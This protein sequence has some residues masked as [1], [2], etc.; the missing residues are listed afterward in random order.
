MVMLMDGSNPVE[1]DPTLASAWQRTLAHA[2]IIL[3]LGPLI[4]PGN[5]MAATVMPVSP[6]TTTS[7]ASNGTPLVNIAAP[8]ASGL[9]Q[10]QYS[11]FDVDPR[12]LIL[13]NSAQPVNT[14]LG[15]YVPGNANVSDGSAR[16]I[17][18]EVTTANPSRLQGYIEVAGSPADVIVANPWGIS[19]E[20]CG[21]LNTARAVLSTGRPQ[22][23]A[24]ERFAGFLVE[25]GTVR[26]E[27]GGLNAS[28]TQ[29]L[30][31]YAR[32]LEVNDALHAQ[33][34]RVVLGTNRID[35]AGN[36]TLLPHDA[37]SAPAYALDSSGLGG[38]YANSIR[39]IGTEAG[40]GMRLAAPVAALTG[41]LEITAS[42][43]VR[44]A[45]SSAATDMRIST[46]HDLVLNENSSAGG[47]AQLTAGGSI[48]VDEDVRLSAADTAL[49]AAS[50]QTRQGSEIAARGS[51]VIAA[52]SQ[53][54]RGQVGSIGHMTLTGDTV[55]SHEQLVASAGL[56]VDALQLVNRGRVDVQEGNLVIRVGQLDNTG[57][58]LRAAGDLNLEMP[59]FSRSL[60]GGDMMAGGWLTVATQG[61]ITIDGEALHTA[62]GVGLQS[63]IGDIR[64]STELTANGDMQLAGQHIRLD[65]PARLLAQGLLQT[66]S[67]DLYN[68]GLM[69]G[70]QGLQ[71]DLTGTLQNGDP[72]LFNGAA[73]LS[74]GNIVIGASNGGSANVVR[75]NGGHIESLAGSIDIR[76]GLLHNLN[77]GWATSPAY[78]L[79]AFEYSISQESFDTFHYCCNRAGEDV[80]SLRTETLTTF[81]DF[82]SLGH[83]G[84]I[85]AS[86][87]IRI[88]A[89]HVIND[90]SVI[91][92]GGVLDIAA[93]QIDNTGTRLTDR[94]TRT[95][96]DHWHTCWYNDVGRL[97]CGARSS[98]PFISHFEGATEVLPAILEGGSAVLLHGTVVNGEAVRVGNSV[99][100]DTGL[101][102]SLATDVP[103][104][105]G[106]VDPTS[107]P[108]FNLPANGIFQRTT[109]PGHRYLI[110]TNPALN[111]Y[112]GFLG[113]AYLLEHLVWAPEITQ[114]RLGD[115]Y[116]EI[117]LIRQALMAALGTRFIDPRVTDER[118]QYEHLMQS[119]V[120]AS[121]TLQISPG[122][123]L[124]REQI[125]AL[126]QDIVWLEERLIQGERVLV[127]VVYLAQGSTRLLQDGAVIGGGALA[128]SG[129]DFH[130]A[131]LVRSSGNISI[132]SAEQLQNVQGS[133]VADGIVQLR[134]GGD[135]LNES[136]VISGHDVLIA[137][138]GNITHRTWS[139]QDEVESRS[140]SSWNTRAGDIATVSA[141]GAV[142]QVA[143][144]DIRLQGAAIA[145]ENVSLV[146]GNSIYLEAISVEEG[147]RYRDSEWQK[148]EENVRHLQ[149][150]IEAA[151]SLSLSA[152]GDI[153]AIA[154]RLAAGGNIELE[155]GRD[156][157][158]L[159]AEDRDYQEAHF[160][161]EGTVGDK[162][163]DMTHDARRLQ[164]SA[165]A[166]GGDVQINAGGN[167]TLYASTVEAAGSGTLAAG[168]NIH[169]VSGVDTVHHSEQSSK[170]KVAT[171][172]THQEGYVQERL[173]T[174][175]IVTG[176]DLALH[177]GNTVQLTGAVLHT[178]KTLTIGHQALD[179]VDPA[180]IPAN[181]IVDTVTLSNQSWNETQKGFRGPVKELVKIASAVMAPMLEMVSL[182]AIKPP[183]IAIGSY[184]KSRLTQT[185]EQGSL[186]Q[187][188]TATITA[189][190]KVTLVNADIHASHRVEIHAT[191][192]EIAAIAETLTR[193]HEKGDET[194]T[195]LGM[196]FGKDELR[197]AG[198]EVVKQSEVHNETLVQWNGTTINADQL[199]LNAKRD[200]SMLAAEINVTG[201]ATLLAGNQLSMGGN[202]ASSTQEHKSI[203]EITTVSAS[204][205]NAYLDAALS[206][207]AL[208]E[209]ADAVKDAKRALDDA[210]SRAVRGE[211]DADDMKY[212]RMNLA[213]ATANLVQM[214]VA[215]ATALAA[216][217]PAGAASA[218][219]GFYV[220]GSAQHE[221]TTVTRTEQQGQWQGSAITVGGNATVSAGNALHVQ[222]SD[223]AVAG[224]L[225]LD[226]QTI[227]L[228]AGE[229]H[230]SSSSQSSSESG[231]V[232]L[233]SKGGGSINVGSQSS[234]GS[235]QGVHY[236]NTHIQAGT[237][238]STSES[239]R[240]AG[241]VIEAEHVN[242][243]TGALA[244]ISQQDW[245]EGRQRS[246]GGSLGAGAGSSGIT[247][248]SLGANFSKTDSERR[249]VDEQSAIIGQDSIRITAKDTQLAGAIIANAARD[250]NGV[251]VD[252]GQL[253]FST[254][255]LSVTHLQD[256]DR[257][258]TVGGNIAVSIP[259]SGSN[260]TA[261]PMQGAPGN[262]PA[263]N[264]SS[265]AA[266]AVAGNGVPFNTFTIGGINTGHVIERTSLATLGAGQLTIGE[267]QGDTVNRDI[268]AAQQV[269][270]DQATGG[271]DASMTIDG[272]WFSEAGRKEMA[273][274]QKKIGTN[275][276]GVVEG[277]GGELSTGVGI[278]VRIAG[279]ENPA[280]MTER[281]AD[282]IG[283]LGL[284]PTNLNN[285][286][287]LAQLPGQLLPGSDFSQKQMVG[288]S[289]DN[290]YVLSNPEMGWVSITELPGYHLLPAAQQANLAN[291]MVSTH[292]T[293]IAVG[294][295][296]YQNST[297]GMLNTPALAMYNAVTQTHNL[298]DDPTQQI[299]VTLNYNPTR[300]VLADGLESAQDKVSIDYKQKWLATNVAVDTGVFVN[301]VLLARGDEQAN[302]ANHSQGNLLNFSGLLA[303]G[304][305][306]GIVFGP[307]DDQNF[308]WNMFGSPVNTI[309]FDAYLKDSGMLL[310]SAS[311][312]DG[313]FVGQRLGG[314]KGLY[315]HEK[316]E[317]VFNVVHHLPENSALFSVLPVTA[318]PLS[319]TKNKSD[320][321][322][323][324]ALFGDSSPHS[325]YSCVARC[326]AEPPP[327]NSP[328]TRVE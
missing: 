96:V 220:S 139:E 144:G 312:N 4:L 176:A 289:A 51:L 296:T 319:Q 147:Y 160:R 228:T 297:N 295:A 196:K 158:L 281:I 304:L 74:E 185:T 149:T 283:L 33:D 15:G 47:R 44:L 302:F 56:S 306:Q 272:R 48:I 55:Q 200:L 72:D 133:I 221:K 172:S 80:H 19:C 203:T 278:A 201:D 6:G 263:G 255:T 100:T 239:L 259:S 119:A 171:F 104:P 163:Y 103:P 113:S 237:V 118:M 301:Q 90:H 184:E 88:R 114:Q 215:M 1:N 218:G 30:S 63:A 307:K 175:G 199:V 274:E 207:K 34:L 42:G 26:I 41:R 32:A 107:L 299:L 321:G 148:T 137:A 2:L 39:L 194:V 320:P 261:G 167:I 130:N 210:E 214:K 127:P 173:A 230:T 94:I 298:I 18:N 271:L 111:T 117:T 46:S 125:D 267:T 264:T 206:V 28:N 305:D 40:L 212:F 120:A 12:G 91:S 269:T 211:L 233:S 328:T 134:S 124:T 242:I 128:I 260:R 244:V 150:Q 54:Y 122:V 188:D 266:E 208:A 247:S 309:D 277:I 16:L 205:R 248:A 236:V 327:R 143:G 36:P 165:V 123:A 57:G 140:T 178:D 98:G 285:G 70:R 183:T 162:T 216:A 20:G 300:G 27:A 135:V 152:A 265:G 276:Q 116:Y 258:K 240:L 180:A 290:P 310:T 253:Q 60:V 303:V 49:T 35:A 232:T 53:Q 318:I 323:F 284:I 181:V 223:I 288:A 17:L 270:R 190:D 170:E 156:V 71:I 141:T 157:T 31:I 115:G 217:V 77:M 95:V 251:L 81:N 225:T 78:S 92:A 138:A 29:R 256:I 231:G 62:G 129:Q 324:G 105:L 97:R 219:T 169:I 10:N 268:A 37:T 177:A 229:E 213:A 275:M 193:T 249:W 204:V 280:A 89:D 82:A 286:G 58:A 325:N 5:A 294:T 238:T 317:N 108:G 50:V 106:V 79:T 243:E 153:T 273:E 132:E 322:K 241:A 326:G 166:A 145:A 191:D 279:V 154:A 192:I 198:V 254:Q 186:L 179:L 311:V 69:Y 168:N 293:A 155:A 308:T 7:S 250:E 282:N 174:S 102:A 68:N 112:Q 234:V 131:G 287:L 76:T 9:S 209:A 227:L 189:H 245:V 13:N 224:T 226:A 313:D 22:L 87:D 316:E 315:V 83:A 182:G 24:E 235:M 121:R 195:G 66:T 262:A 99:V 110:E 14:Q 45:R 142:Q 21:F 146:A 202:E 25:G 75:N 246:E 8:N 291:V 64:I 151:Q 257:H 73:I 11:Q 164:G 84:Q 101:F 126:Q 67:G 222:G 61:D 59:T 252:Q 187:A 38:M 109:Q 85:M 197:L 23:D 65:A 52:Q 314:N 292:P 3:Q 159:A 43:D 86:G 136:G 93:A 161:H